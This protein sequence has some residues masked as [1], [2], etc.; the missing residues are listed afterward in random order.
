MDWYSLKLSMLIRI[1]IRYIYVIY[2]RYIYYTHI[3]TMLIYILIH[4][5]I[6]SFF[7]SFLHS[8]SISVV[9]LLLKDRLCKTG[10]ERL[11]PYQSKDPIKTIL[12]YRKKSESGNNRRQKCSEQH[13]PI[14]YHWTCS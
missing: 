8:F 7:R 2:I 9:L 4:S 1:Y 12:T 11:K 13:R 14:K 6:R 10:R 5:Y 3:Y